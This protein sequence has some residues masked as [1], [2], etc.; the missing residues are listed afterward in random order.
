MT[1]S[2]PKLLA[3]HQIG[4]VVID[5][6]GAIFRTET[7]DSFRRALVMRRLVASLLELS[8]KYS[9]C[10]IVCVNQVNFLCAI[11]TNN[12]SKNM[13]LQV[14]SVINSTDSERVSVPCLGLAWASLVGTRI[15]LHRK[16][17]S[18][19]CSISNHHN[20]KI[21]NATDETILREMEIVFSPHVY[22]SKA[23][24]VITAEG[25]TD[26]PEQ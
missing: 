18:V 12:I 6:V 15:Q 7:S 17:Q 21:E 5:S 23:A 24:F 16:L 20:V 9:P 1:V 8:T 13:Y 2:L 11:I 3:E 22:P 25:V 14:T 10:A 19:V 26:V 4:L